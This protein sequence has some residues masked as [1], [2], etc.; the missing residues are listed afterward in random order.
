MDVT[1]ELCDHV[2]VG[3]RHHGAKVGFEFDP[4]MLPEIFASFE[5]MRHGP[6]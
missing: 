1:A 6:A 4:T 3:P 5:R 2:Y